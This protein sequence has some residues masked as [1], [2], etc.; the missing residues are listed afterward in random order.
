MAE[1]AIEKALS[2]EK[3]PSGPDWRAL[4]LR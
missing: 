1:F 2:H 3:T 4:M